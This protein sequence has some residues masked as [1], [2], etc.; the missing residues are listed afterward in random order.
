MDAILRSGGHVFYNQLK[1]V[2]RKGGFDSFIETLCGNG[3]RCSAGS[4]LHPSW[5][6][7][8]HQFAGGADS[9]NWLRAQLLECPGS[10]RATPWQASTSDCCCVQRFGGRSPKRL[11]YRLEGVFCTLGDEILCFLCFLAPDLKGFGLMVSGDYCQ[12]F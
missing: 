9:G 8:S 10:R 5:V 4:A 7:Y 11:A 3:L 2:L 6:G 1:R 12:F